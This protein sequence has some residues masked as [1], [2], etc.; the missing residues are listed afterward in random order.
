[1]LQ[2]RIQGFSD[3]GRESLRWERQSIIWPKF[4][5]KLH[6]TLS[7]VLPF[8]IRQCIET[9]I[10]RFYFLPLTEDC[11]DNDE[12]APTP[13]YPRNFNVGDLVW[14]KIRG[15]ESWPGKLVHESEVKLHHNSKTDIKSSDNLVS[16]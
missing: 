12:E 7:P 16:F 6:W 8:S 5:P 3:G 2:W 15:F 14:G 4:P 11:S 13:T 10:W 1:M 9:L